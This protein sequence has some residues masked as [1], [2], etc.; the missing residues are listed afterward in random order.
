MLLAS[1]PLT[2]PSGSFKLGYFLQRSALA[3][4]H[5]SVNEGGVRLNSIGIS[6]TSTTSRSSKGSGPG[7]GDKYLQ[8]TS[9]STSTGPG[10]S[11]IPYGFESPFKENI[12]E[13][14]K[15][16]AY[17]L[18]RVFI[19]LQ[20]RCPPPPAWGWYKLLAVLFS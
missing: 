10:H 15:S 12:D 16:F 18:L 11:V 9:S 3:Y 5:D 19:A 2:Y 4:H 8:S 1:F 7:K 14:L 20:R 13:G 17:F 6:T